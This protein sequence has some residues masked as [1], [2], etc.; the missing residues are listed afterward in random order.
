MT[1]EPGRFRLFVRRHWPALRLRT[2]LLSVLL[3]AALL[4]GFAGIFLRVYENTLVRQTEAELVAQTAALSATAEALWPGSRLSVPTQVQR[5]TPGWYRPETGTIDLGSTPVLP[6]RPP[7]APAA[8]PRPDAVVV[9]ERLDPI[10][11]E[12][13]RTT[14]ASIILLDRD[15]TVVR[16]FGQGGGWKALPEVRAALAGR[17]STVLRRNADYRPRYSMEWLSRASALRIHHARPVTVNGRVEG[18]I[19]VSRSPR[20]LFRGVYQDRIKIALGIVGVL[21]FIAFLAVLVSRGIA[22]PIERLSRVTREV[23][24]GGGEVPPPP[25]TAAVE[26][27]TLY[28]DFGVM[29][30][31]IERRSR[32]LR[33]F[34]AAVSHEFKTPLAGINGAV[35]LLQDHEDMSPAERR[36]FLDNIAGDGRRLSALVTR[37]MD[38]AR[39]DMARPEAGLSVDIRPPL[40]KAVD[41]ASP[42][43]AVELDLPDALPPVAAPEATLEVVV[44]TMLENSRQAGASSVRIAGRVAGE[45][46]V[47]SI[48]DDGPGIA[49][50][51]R[52]RIFEPF[53][54]TRRSEGGAGLG[55]SI[56]RALLAANQAT[57]DLAPSGDGAVFEIGLPLAG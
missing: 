5:D 37:L 35:E 12:T 3:F 21:G 30:K 18:V 29:A 44:A 46:V 11:E 53:F 42:D 56:A 33:D 17:P 57:L 38:L 10:M 36:R 1:G 6:A 31:A 2:I 51:D 20:A 9:G 25:A 28:E 45:T 50:A 48:R 24:A 49:P 27:R 7:T 55:L 54:T 8:P 22:R 34:A 47:L 23:A 41:A 4:P 15:G 16:G 52:Q 39:A 32:Y 19:L 13:S 40:L 26:I 43:L 14:L